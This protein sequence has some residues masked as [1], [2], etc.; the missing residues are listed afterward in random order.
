MANKQKGK[1]L[2]HRPTLLEYIVSSKV[3]NQSP[4]D[5]RKGSVFFFWLNLFPFDW[6]FQIKT[7]VQLEAAYS[8]LGKIGPEELKLHEFEEACGVGKDYC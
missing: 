4:A 2:V 8:F 6:N 5:G 7:P 3:R 1:A